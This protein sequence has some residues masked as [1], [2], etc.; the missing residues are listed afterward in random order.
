MN[1]NLDE[2][3]GFKIE[4]TQRKL[5]R[6]WI[7]L[8]RKQGIDITPNH[9]VI[10]Y[11]LVE[12]EG[13]TQVEISKRTFKDTANITHILDLLVK[14]ELVER[15]PVESDRRVFRIYLTDKSRSLMKTVPKI[16]ASNLRAVTKGIS[17]EEIETT[18]KVLEKMYANLS[19][20][21]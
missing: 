17:K 21:N 13:L 10:L 11:R 14:K 8:F 3:I 7:K 15:V 9:W 19:Q 2:S 16:V 6:E 12:E 5:K 1:F 20:E 18:K 4:I